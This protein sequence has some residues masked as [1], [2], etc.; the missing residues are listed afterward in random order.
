VVVAKVVNGCGGQDR[1][2]GQDRRLVKTR[3]VKTG[4][5]RQ[6]GQDRKVGQDTRLVKTGWSRQKGWSRHKVGQ[7][8]VGQDRRLVKTEGWRRRKVQE[9]IK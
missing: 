8:K 3:L 7:D 5:S 1:K 9:W 4:W 6:V 2:V